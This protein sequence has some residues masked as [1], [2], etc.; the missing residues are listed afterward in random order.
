[1][2]IGREYSPF[3]ESDKIEIKGD[4]KYSYTFCQEGSGKS[5]SI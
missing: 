4:G 3:K 2:K 1:M 5:L